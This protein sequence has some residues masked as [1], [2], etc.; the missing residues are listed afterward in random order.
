MSQSIVRLNSNVF[1]QSLE[2]GQWQWYSDVKQQAV[3]H[4]SGSPQHQTGEADIFVFIDT[5]G[6][7]TTYAWTLGGLGY[8]RS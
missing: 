7:N 6:L 5:P 1:S 8:D 2:D 3:P 4:T